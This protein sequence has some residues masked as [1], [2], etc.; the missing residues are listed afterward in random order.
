MIDLIFW[1]A[2]ISFFVTIGF[3]CLVGYCIFYTEET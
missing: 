3:V 1:I 2:N